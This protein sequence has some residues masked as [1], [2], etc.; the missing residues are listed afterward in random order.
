VAASRRIEDNL[1]V[2]VAAVRE[3][4]SAMLSLRDG[5]T[6]HALVWPGRG[7]PLVLLHGLLDSAQ[8]WSD[9]CR[10]TKRPCVAFDLGG[11]GASDLPARPS[12][13]G[14][15]D[16]VVEGMRLLGLGK[17]VVVGH[18][19]GGGVAAAVAERV[20]Q[21]VLALVLLAP[22]GFGRIALADLVSLPGVRNVADRFLPFALGNRATVAA[23]YRAM[24][25][26]GLDP[27]DDIVSR[28]VDH[29][30]AL[31]AA[32]REGTKAV[33]RAS[34][35]RHAFHRRKLRYNGPVAAVWGTRDRLVPIGHMAGVA[36]AFPQVETHVWDRMGH[37]HQRERPTELAALVESTCRPFDRASRAARRTAA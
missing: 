18:S 31:A 20:P 13:G 24:I 11:F 2:S 12:L 8:G 29:R 22:A 1:R 4:T 5:R 23:A 35:S 37:H 32:A 26:A 28:V 30:A 10:A 9:F 25:A 7:T 27:T 17:V 3:P 36:T 19:L 14:Y 33:V 16:D 6:A 34:A 15:A 21:R